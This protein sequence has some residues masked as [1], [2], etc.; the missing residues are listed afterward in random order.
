MKDL[1]RYARIRSPRGTFLAWQTANKKSV[2]RLENAGLGGL[3]IRTPEPPR[4]GAYI[5]L[6]LDVPAGE[7]RAR[8]VV[9]RIE[10]GGMAVKFIAMQPEARGRFARWIKSL[11]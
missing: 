10:A 11:V 9:L 1:R 5:Q 2:S 7:V 3:Y 8:A 6:L 4:P